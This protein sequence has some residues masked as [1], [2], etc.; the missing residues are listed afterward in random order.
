MIRNCP[1]CGVS[2][3]VVR[4][5]TGGKFGL[6]PE[7]LAIGDDRLCA[8]VVGGFAWKPLSVAQAI[9]IE[10]RVSLDE[11]MLRAERELDWHLPHVCAGKVSV[12]A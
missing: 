12:P 5:A 3:L 10:T 11:A 8:V 2:V 4:G 1:L 7:P 9:A 6:Q